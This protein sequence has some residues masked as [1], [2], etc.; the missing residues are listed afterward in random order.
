MKIL[1]SA[2]ASLAIA[3]A[4]PGTSVAQEDEPAVASPE[5]SAHRQLIAVMS[6]DSLHE[7][8]FGN[9]V[10]QLRAF[11]MDSPDFVLLEK[12]CPG[13]ID[14]M[15]KTAEPA[16]REYHF[17][18]ADMV[19]DLLLEIFTEH[20]TPEQA[21]EG[22]ELYGSPIGQK[23]I[24]SAGQN[25]NLQSTMESAAENNGR[26]VDRA[27]FDRDNRATTSRILQT[28][29]REEIEEFGNRAMQTQFIG[30]FQKLNPLIQQRKFQLLNSDALS[31]YEGRM[32]KAMESAM[33]DHL[34]RCE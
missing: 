25:Q 30:A 29:T 24:L 23:M 5:L 12:E 2:V 10:R 17:A 6:P 15:L 4:L 14:G 1:F 16:M 8:A 7:A 9:T 28:L 32:Q 20:L 22:V 3:F 11:Y 13:L 26:S 19:R 18:E 33:T 31:D 21:R 27:A 34:E